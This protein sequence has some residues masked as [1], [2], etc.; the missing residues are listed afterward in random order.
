MKQNQNMDHS[1]DEDSQDGS[2]NDSKNKSKIDNSDSDEQEDPKDYCKGG[3]HH[4]E[5]GEVYNERY[6][7]LRKVGWGHFSTVWL[8]WDLKLARY[9]ALKV[10]KSAKHYTETAIDEI[11][12]LRCVS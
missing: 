10:V 9:V 12:L 4:V 8:A 1:Y 6:K 3:Y 2:I 11:K 5:I 7:I